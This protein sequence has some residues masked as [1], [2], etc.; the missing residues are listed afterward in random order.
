[1]RRPRSCPDLRQKLHFRFRGMVGAT[2]AQHTQTGQLPDA[3]K[4]QVKVIL[5]NTNRFLSILAG[6]ALGAGLSGVSAETL[7]NALVSAYRT[8]DLLEQNQAVL[9]AADEDVATSVS[10]LRP[11]INW[12]LQSQFSDGPLGNSSAAELQLN[13][14]WN[15]YDFGRSKLGVEIAKETVLA[16]REALLGV[17]QNVLLSAVQAYMDLRRANATVAIGQTSVRVIGEQLKATQDRM[18]LGDATRIDVSQAEAGLAS[19]RATLAVAE[20]DLAMARSA[21]LAEIGHAAD[22]KTTIPPT[23][24]LPKTLAEAQSIAQRL[25]PA[26]LQAQHQAKAADLQVELAAAQR[27][28]TLG[29]NLQV[30]EGDSGDTSGLAALQLSQTIYAGGKLS[31]QHRKA[32]AGRDQSRAALT[33]TGVLIK[34]SVSNAWSG[35]E[36][37]RAQIVAIDRQIDAASAVYEGIRDQAALGSSTTLDVLNAEQDLRQAR[38]NRATAEANLQVALYSLLASM[39]LLTV[40]HLNL[41]IPTYDPEGYYNAVKSAPATS[42]QGK[43][44]DRVLKAIGKN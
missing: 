5:K 42:V 13:L 30:A 21:Y 25:H 7:G 29:L 32:I 15:L 14:N 16:T 1:M 18:S 22:S 28:P 23:P 24:A 17:E 11:V 44:L 12:V 31:S 26:I 35:I 33:R 9:R 8:S 34:Q 2:V 43:S 37:A 27:R 36:V 41:G 10:S 38:S 40:D 4:G 6:A 3:D 39:G 20:G 19:A